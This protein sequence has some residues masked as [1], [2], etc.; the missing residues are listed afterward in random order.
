MDRSTEIYETETKFPTRASYAQRWVH[1]DQ[2]HL[3]S[4]MQGVGMTWYVGGGRQGRPENVEAFENSVCI[5]DSAV[6]SM[7]VA[8][9][10]ATTI[11]TERRLGARSCGASV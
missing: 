6:V 5:C 1:Q 4:R 8:I 7:Y 10:V 11:A 9:R 2:L 3:D